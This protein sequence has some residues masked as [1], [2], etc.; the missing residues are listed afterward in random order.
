MRFWRMPSRSYLNDSTP[1]R[2]LLLLNMC[3]Y[4][5]ESF[6]FTVPKQFAHTQNVPNSVTYVNVCKRISIYFCASNRSSPARIRWNIY[7]SRAL[8]S[9]INLR[10]PFSN[11]Y[12]WH[13][14]RAA[15]G[16]AVC[17]GNVS[18]KYVWV[19]QSIRK[20]VWGR[21]AGFEGIHNV[22]M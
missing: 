21:G 2:L 12:M 15:G 14:W 18:H 3:A 17:C 22:G 8:A 7:K 16:A 19:I 9:R 1:R 10:N 6:R 4:L 20:C 5:Q 13:V 11:A